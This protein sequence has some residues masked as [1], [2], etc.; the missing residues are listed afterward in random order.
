M[1][2]TDLSAV[3]GDVSDDDWR[4]LAELDVRFAFLRLVV[5]NEPWTDV[6]VAKRNAERARAHGILV[7]PY[8]FAYPLPHLLPDAQVEHLFALVEQLGELGMPPALDLEW[9][10]RETRRK[11]QTLEDTWKKWGC[12]PVQLREWGLRALERGVELTGS[13]WFV[14]SFR[15]WLQCIEAAKS[16]ELG[17]YPLWL[18]DYS[19]KGRWPERPEIERL[20][21]PAP[22]QQITIVQHDGD[23]GLKLPSARDADFSVGLIDP[24]DLLQRG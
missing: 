2:G 20:T 1:R 5:G 11:D 7:A 4:K 23:G 17:D 8:L 9:P 15:Y 10:P 21:V 18:A 13:P 14:Y 24:A 19:F 6:G 3:Q 16:P 12:S 22:W